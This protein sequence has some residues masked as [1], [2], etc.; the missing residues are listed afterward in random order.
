MNDELDLPKKTVEH[1]VGMA[2]DELSIDELKKRILLLE[3]EIK[4]LKSS[5][6]SKSASH[7]LANA[8]F[9]L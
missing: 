2:L 5:I 7:E 4:R 9:K 8:A 6:K 3:D 1:E